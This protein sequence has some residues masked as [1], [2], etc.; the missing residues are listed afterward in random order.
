M[1][2]ATTYFQENTFFEYRSCSRNPI[3]VADAGP[4]GQIAAL[5]LAKRADQT[6]RIGR[7]LL[8][9]TDPLDQR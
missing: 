2:N 8:L 4:V 9:P 6:F 3:I 1:L 5:L 7:I